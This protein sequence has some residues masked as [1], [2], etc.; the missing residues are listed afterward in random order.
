MK[1][2]S[3]GLCSVFV[4]L[5]REPDNGIMDAAG[6]ANLNSHPMRPGPAIESS[7]Y[8]PD[9]TSYEASLLTK[10]RSY[11]YAVL[12]FGKNRISAGYS[13]KILTMQNCST[14]R[15][16]EIKKEWGYHLYH[17]G[18]LLLVNLMGYPV[19]T[20]L[21]TNLHHQLKFIICIE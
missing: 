13:A 15:E 2:R 6:I 19:L 1:H 20:F 4:W 10:Y 8:F 11:G 7:S 12:V 17:R 21:A 14:Y 16:Q 9:A 18:T 5:S 3:K